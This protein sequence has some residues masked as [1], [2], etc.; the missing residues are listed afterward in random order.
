MFL[1][2]LQKKPHENEAEIDEERVN[3]RRQTSLEIQI[4]S[5]ESDNLAERTSFF[6]F[7]PLMMR[8]NAHRE[9]SNEMMSFT[10]NCFW[11][12]SHYERPKKA[13]E[14]RE[15]KRFLKEK[16]ILQEPRLILRSKNQP[17]TLK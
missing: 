5:L 11:F 3:L 9:L 4:L 1:M 14:I 17:Q 7:F 12:S 10:F 8:V 13:R 16:L 6:S 2:A 15:L